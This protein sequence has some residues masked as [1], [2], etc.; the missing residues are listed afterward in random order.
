MH[1][2]LHAVKG[3]V[4]RANVVVGE[5]DPHFVRLCV[6]AIDPPLMPLVVFEQHAHH[7]A[8]AARDSVMMEP[9]GICPVDHRVSGGGGGRES[10]RVLR[11]HVLISVFLNAVLVHG[12]AAVAAPVAALSHRG[13][14]AFFFL[15][16]CEEHG[17]GRL[18]NWWEISL[19]AYS[20]RTGDAPPARREGLLD[21]AL[22]M[23][24]SEG[25]CPG[26]SLPPERVDANRLLSSRSLPSVL[27]E[28]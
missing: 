17:G 1:P 24:I 27:P 7:G 26:L 19:G 23:L 25:G 10:V 12:E 2:H 6:K 4:D 20:D 3:C 28:A 18:V 16:P 15:F 8:L 22:R 13:Q 5:L 14:P 9:H 11:V 21:D